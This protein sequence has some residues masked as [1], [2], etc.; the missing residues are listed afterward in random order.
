MLPSPPQVSF[1]LQSTSRT[2]R[3]AEGT[4]RSPGFS[5]ALSCPAALYYVK[6]LAWQAVAH[7]LG[8]DDIH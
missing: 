2:K 1:L 3:H 7:L 8:V 5:Q 6:N 4:S